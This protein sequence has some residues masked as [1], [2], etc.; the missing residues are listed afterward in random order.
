MLEP[1]HATTAVASR[2]MPSVLPATA[3]ALLI[4]FAALVL[5]FGVA[6]PSASAHDT[7]LSSD[8]ED[9]A[10]LETSPDEITLSYS[11]DI[12]EVSPVVRIVDADGATVL[13]ETPQVDGT[14]AVLPLDGG[15]APGDYDV[16]WRVVSSDGHPI[17]GSFSISVTGG[18]GTLGAAPTAA[19]ESAP[20]DAGGASADDGS[21]TA[22]D[23]PVGQGSGSAADEDANNATASSE[24]ESSG[25]P[26]PVLI[27]G[28]AVL[29]IAVAAA[30]V[31]A[32]RSSGGRSGS[33]DS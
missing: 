14:K 18:D 17:E 7:L 22:E 26:L 20:S 9:G 1:S 25:L 3:R 16:L 23:S 6:L 10:V 30:V 33:Q 2:T 5:S 31:F 27:A 4:G 19:E 28:A 8:P 21:T 11:A 29:L 13:E 24:E 12:L 32:L 15:L